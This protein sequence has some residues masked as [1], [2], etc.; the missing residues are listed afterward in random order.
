MKDESC[1]FQ[2]H[3]HSLKYHPTPIRTTD[4]DM[5][6]MT[7]TMSILPIRQKNNTDDIADFDTKTSGGYWYCYQDFKPR[8]L[9]LHFL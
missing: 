2:C 5:A 6:N 3:Q 1:G 7:E 4:T 9:L 8:S